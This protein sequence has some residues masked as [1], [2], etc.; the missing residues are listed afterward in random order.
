MEINILEESKTKL[1]FQLP[2]ETHTFC[3]ALKKE[4]QGVD[5]VVVATYR[6][7]HPLIGIPEFLLE[8]KGVEPKEAIKKALKALKKKAEEFKK[9]A[10]SL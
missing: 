10:K 3:N 5:G 7:E 2:S 9:E 8:T 1:V 4:L 6:V